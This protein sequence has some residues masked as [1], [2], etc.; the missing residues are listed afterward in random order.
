MGSV[1]LTVIENTNNGEMNTYMEE[2]LFSLNLLVQF[3]RF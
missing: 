1:F 3:K 2:V